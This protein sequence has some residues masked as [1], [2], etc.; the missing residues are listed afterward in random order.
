MSKPAVLI[1]LLVLGR[2]KV[3]AFQQEHLPTKVTDP[4]VVR[5][6]YK[7]VHVFDNFCSDQNLVYWAD[8]GTFLGVVRCRG[9]MQHDDDLD[10]AMPLADFNRL[11]TDSAILASLDK[12]GLKLV[13]FDYGYKICFKTATYPVKE[14]RPPPPPPGKAGWPKWCHTEATFPFIDIFAVNVDTK[15]KMFAGYAW[16]KCAKWKHHH[17]SR[18]NLLPI[19]RVKF[20]AGEINRPRTTYYLDQFYPDH[21]TWMK[22]QKFDHQTNTPTTR[23]IAPIKITGVLEPLKPFH[24]PHETGT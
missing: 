14:I 19:A 11:V 17:G 18:D 4:L 13:E 22:W 24:D 5:C 1:R 10:V 15:K 9:I 3:K 20:G 23:K 21:M 6:M 12:L 8:G 16:K 2:K 7:L